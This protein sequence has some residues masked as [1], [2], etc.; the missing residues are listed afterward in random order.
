M[1]LVVCSVYNV[2][3]NAYYA[4]FRPP[5]YT[6]EFVLDMVMEVMFF[7]DIIFCFF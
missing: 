6:Y 7:F 5:L 2:F 1:L 3:S 4:A